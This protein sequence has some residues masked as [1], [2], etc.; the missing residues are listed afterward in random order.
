MAVPIYLEHVIE[1]IKMPSSRFCH[2]Q[3]ALNKNLSV[4][5]IHSS[6]W[7]L[8]TNSASASLPLRNFAGRCMHK[9]D[10]V[11]ATLPSANPGNTHEQTLP[12][13]SCLEQALLVPSRPEQ[14]PGNIKPARLRIATAFKIDP[15]VI[16]L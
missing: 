9:K 6:A 14:T 10:L 3:T 15:M 12:V 16:L 4:F 11:S 7:L 5:P 1:H 13:P 8:R 2:R